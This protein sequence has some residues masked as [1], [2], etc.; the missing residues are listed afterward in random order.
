[1]S[2]DTVGRAEMVDVRLEFEDVGSERH[3][4]VGFA[5]VVDAAID[6]I[7][8]RMWLDHW[9]LVAWRAM[10]FSFECPTIWWG[11]QR[12]RTKTVAVD[13]GNRSSNRRYCWPWTGL[14]DGS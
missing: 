12:W 13:A 3:G 7:V 5:V 6:A 8:C 11:G 1:M 4:A 9:L 2:E 14:C 10:T